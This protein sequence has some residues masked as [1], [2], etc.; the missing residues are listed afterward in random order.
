MWI[1]L[2][3]Q[4]SSSS[5]AAVHVAASYYYQQQEYPYSQPT[6]QYATP[7]GGAYSTGM[8]QQPLVHALT[9]A[10]LCEMPTVTIEQVKK[11][12]KDW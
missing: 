12:L 6:S 2:Q 8:E 9:A 11:K 7:M 1:S 3:A 10:P 5:A 4:D